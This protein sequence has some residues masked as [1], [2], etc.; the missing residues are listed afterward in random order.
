MSGVISIGS[1]PVAGE[2]AASD[3]FSIT[4]DGDDIRIA[5]GL[6]HINGRRAR[7]TRRPLGVAALLHFTNNERWFVGSALYRLDPPIQVSEYGALVLATY[8]IVANLP[9]TDRYSRATTVFAA[10]GRGTLFGRYA[11]YDDYVGAEVGPRLLGGHNHRRV[12]S[13][14]QGGYEIDATNTRQRG[15]T[16]K[17]RKS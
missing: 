3:T 17:S 7:G 12:L 14:L 4:A 15:R 1:A 11:D 2:Q 16:N 5:D 10:S 9:A 6:Y 8:V 13:A